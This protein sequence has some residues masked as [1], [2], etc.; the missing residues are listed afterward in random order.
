M[1]KDSQII[2]DTYD[3]GNIQSIESINKGISSQA[4]LVITS[5]GKYIFRKLNNIHQAHTEYKIASVLFIANICP[6]ILLTLE[7]LPYIDYKGNIYNLQIY[8]ENGFQ[9]N[10]F[11]M[12]QLGKIVSIFHRQLKDASLYE[13]EDRFQLDVLWDEVCRKHHNMLGM[14]TKLSEQ[15]HICSQYDH[16]QN[17][18]IHGDLGKWNFIFSDTNPMIIDFGE[19]RKGNYHF[20]IAAVITSFLNMNASKQ[21]MIAALN[22]F[23]EGYNH[24]T[25]MIDRM[26]LMENIRLWIVRR[27]IA[28]LNQNGVTKETIAFSEKMMN[29][30]H[31][32]EEILI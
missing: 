5:S 25:I 8:I 16:P 9:T 12:A 7:N 17:C 3:I 22:D 11:N 6:Q 29:V 1:L 2:A 14:L 28:V 20:D 15:V 19:V 18:Y 26:V 4:K 21:D 24:L 30:I 23:E 31:K 13:Q 32:Y 27:I 10:K